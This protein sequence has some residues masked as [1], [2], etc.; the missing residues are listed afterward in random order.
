[1]AK[2]FRLMSSLRTKDIGNILNVNDRCG[3][4]FAS[5]IIRLIGKIYSLT[6]HFISVG[7][8]RFRISK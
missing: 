8:V 6:K 4:I 1:M 7:N 5:Q 3:D 2:I